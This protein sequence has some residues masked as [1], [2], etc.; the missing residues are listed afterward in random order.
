MTLEEM[1]KKLEAAE[2]A[3]KAKENEIESLKSQRANQN[4]YITKLEQK[5]QTLE[6]NLSTVKNTVNNA[7]AMDPA[8]TEYFRKKR[9]EDYTKEAFEEIISQVGAEKLEILKKDLEDFLKSYMTEANVSVKY[10]IDAFHLLLGKAY[11][12]PKHPIHGQGAVNPADDTPVK[13]EVDTTKITEQITRMQYPGM[14]NDDQP[15]ATPSPVEPPKV[16]NTKEAMASFK[17]RL[18]N[19]GL[20]SNRFE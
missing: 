9:R 11:A 20:N 2:A 17:N 3:A 12:D 8:I 19:G 13:P 4:A 18:F 6:S 16:A 5:A 10:I 7:P 1:Q 15:M 14:T